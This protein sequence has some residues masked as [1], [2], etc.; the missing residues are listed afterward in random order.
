MFADNSGLGIALIFTGAGL[1]GL[2]PLLLRRLPRRNKKTSPVEAEELHPL[3]TPAISLNEAAVFVVQR[4]GRVAYMNPLGRTWFEVGDNE[5]PNLERMARQV[6][7][8][9]A[10]YSLCAIQGEV[11]FSLNHTMVEGISFAIPYQNE[12]A[13]L[14]TLKQPKITGS[15]DGQDNLSSYAV[16]I[17]T[18]ISQAMSASLEL[19]TTIETILESIDRLIPSDFSEITL[20]NPESIEFTPY[21]YLIEDDGVRRLSISPTYY[22][23][24]TGY[25]G[26][27]ASQTEALLVK[28]ISQFQE[29]RPAVNRAQFP[30]RSYLGI[31]LRMGGV[32]IGT[33][34]LASQSVDGFTEQDKEILDLLSGHAGVALQNA[35]IHNKEQVRIKEM[36]GLAELAQV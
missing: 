15:E 5:T 32:L 21:R 27:M 4:G 9:D 6:R 1:L 35:I 24:G 33:I 31:S 14:V 11:N 10:F 26:Y 3:T 8:T 18:E 7:P 22:T 16:T 17:F 12:A 23:L 2:V 30:I 20:F 25:T 36:A 19:E 29:A 34:E 28:D 13:I